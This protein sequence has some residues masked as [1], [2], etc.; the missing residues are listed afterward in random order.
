MTDSARVRA[1]RANAEKSTGPRT[2]AGRRR[3]ATNALRHGLSVPVDASPELDARATELAR[4]IAGDGAS[5]RCFEVARRVAE[6]QIDITRVRAAKLLILNGSIRAA[7]RPQDS[8]KLVRLAAKVL[9]GDAKSY[10]A[11]EAVQKRVDSAQEGCEPEQIAARIVGASY[12][13]AKFDRYERRALSRRKFAIRDL[14]ALAA[15]S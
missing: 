11:M 13:L 9:D 7:L 12:E 1:N 10:A 15:P 2:G 8:M 14:D 3:V 6:A 4:R 5:A